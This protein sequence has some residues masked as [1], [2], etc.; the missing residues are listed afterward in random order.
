[1]EEPGSSLDNFEGTMIVMPAKAGIQELQQ[2]SLK[3]TNLDSR[4]RGNDASSVYPSN[5]NW[6]NTRTPPRAHGIVY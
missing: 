6:Q 2:K 3:L 1:M 4:F 5:A